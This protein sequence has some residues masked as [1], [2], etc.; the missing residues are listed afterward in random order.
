MV[1]LLAILAGLDGLL[2]CI[3][4]VFFVLSALTSHEAAPR[5]ETRRIATY[6]GLLLILIGVGNVLIYYT[7]GL[8]LYLERGG[9]A[10]VGVAAAIARALAA[11]LL[12][13]LIVNSLR[14][15]R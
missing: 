9:A 6:L 13:L 1:E 11:G 4:G 3:L 12:L 2:G 7:G 5:R 8:G 10:S 15:W 14:I